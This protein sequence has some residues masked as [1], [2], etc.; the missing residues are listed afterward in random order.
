[1]A[2]EILTPGAGQVRA[3][4]TL[5]T[6]PVRSTANSDQMEAAFSSLD[7]FVAVDFYI[8]ETTRHAHLILP[9]PTAT[10]QECYELGF[11]QLSVRNFT[12]WSSAA[13]PTPPETPASWQVMLK[14]A[15]IF[16]G[17]ADQ[18]LQEVD[19]AVFA[20]MAGNLL[21]RNCP[22]NDLTL[23][24]VVTKLAGSAGP[25]RT[26][27]LLLRIGPYGDGFGRRSGGLTLAKV[28]ES[29]HGIDLGPLTPRLREI[30]NTAS[31]MVEL[32]PPAITNDIARLR[33]RMKDRTGEMLLIGRRNLRTSNSFMHNLPALVKGRDVCTLQMSPRD[34]LRIGV[35]DGGSA[36]VSSRVG[37]V[38]A[39]VEIT[40]DLMPGVVSLP[41]GWGH[42]VA[43]SRLAVAKRHAG[44]NAN[45]LTDDRAYDEAS[46][47]T[48]LFGTP[49]SI[50]PV[51]TAIK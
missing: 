42:D 26:I 23:D 30:I 39:P 13:L 44:V 41:H 31:G 14:L 22:W 16:L 50:E 25:T 8:N 5:M 37:S 29:E 4:I 27:D 28:R 43:S 51:A 40:E 11:Y 9:T 7:F 49:V 15:A 46:G 3:M 45:A 17:K 21:K 10:E 19:D 18:P 6:N 20:Q 38:V 1:M 48:V 12:K 32:A 47:A 36:R 34:A 35:A 33:S 2:E 24:E